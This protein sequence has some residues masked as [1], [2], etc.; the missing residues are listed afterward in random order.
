MAK[1]HATYTR[2]FLTILTEIFGAFVCAFSRSQYV[3]VY[4]FISH[5]ID[6]IERG[7]RPGKT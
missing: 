6:N 3:Y 1:A 7:K 2:T 4:S 5:E